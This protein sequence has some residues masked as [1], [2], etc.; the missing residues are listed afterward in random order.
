MRY[1]P[2]R[3]IA[4]L[5]FCLFAVGGAM[6]QTPEPLV[7]PRLHGPVILDGLS[8]EPAWDVAEPLPVVQ[9]EPDPGEPPTQKTEIRV[10]YDDQYLYFSLRAYDTDPHGIRANTLYR[11]RLSGDDHFEIM[12]DT[13]NDNENAILFTTTPA[14]IRRDATVSN[15][16]S[17]GGV[18]SGGWLNT[19][20]NTYWDVK[21]VVN[22]QGWFAELRIP[23][24]SL[25]FQSENGRVVMGFSVQRKV[26]R[27]SERLIYPAVPP[28]INWGFLKPS[29]G[30]K[31]VLEGIY[32]H[33]PVYVTPYILSGLSQ[34][35]RWNDAR[36]AYLSDNNVERDIGGDL[37]Y[38]LTNNLSL[39]LTINTDFAQVEADDQ[40]INLTRFSLFYPEKRQFFQ[41]RAS[42]LEFR[43]GGVSRLFHS[44]R[45]GL[46]EQG[47]QVPIIGG[48]R[49]VG[50]VGEWD[51]GAL[52]MQTAESGAL[53]SENFG[54][55][56]LRRRAFNPYSY[57]GGMST[58][59]IGTDGSYNAAYG[60]DGVFRLAGDDYLTLQWAQTFDSDL[61]EASALD[62]F[63]T[64][65]FVANLERR[66]RQG[67]GYNVGMVW[68]GRHYNPGIGFVQRT[69]YLLFDNTVSYSWLPG[70]GSDLLYHTLGVRGIVFMRNED[71][72]VESAEIGPEWE[73]GRRSGGTALV[74]AKVL[75]EDL[76]FP[77]AIARDAEVPAGTYSFYQGTVSYSMPRT[78]LLQLGIAVSAGS[79][80]DGWRLAVGL[81]P[82]WYVSPHL[83]LTGE[84]HWDR[85]RFPDRN[86]GFDA[87][88]ARLRIGTALNTNLSTNAF[89]QYN[90][91]T[92][93]VSANVRFRYN[94]REGNDLWIVYNEGLN[95]NRSRAFPTPSLPLTD[96]RTIL[97]K[98]T[99]TF[100]L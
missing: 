21:T 8:F 100:S 45:I 29:L 50:R 36:A 84:Y 12:L 53:P 67:P 2:K 15:D 95:T 27:R 91:A 79:F 49:L 22:D 33:N 74:E 18:L 4:L 88:I 72:S 9:Y 65:L 39:D 81:T 68:S 60:L 28:S 31:M 78:Q 89:I 34:A 51:L 64:A 5:C 40:Q 62:A 35:N 70:A 57:A 55:F 92:E 56:R 11:D 3:T 10:A 17:G 48:A 73:L 90:S 20:Y 38:G 83:E 44:R 41:E 76:V 16:A 86:Q 98:Y 25:R 14:G 52:N 32:P 80:Y 26:A 87:H 75:V 66:R 30:R 77:F 47:V 54:V 13:Y 93:A 6:A 23:F 37:K 19:S 43:T 96:S 46:T 61:I 99:H 82:V 85:V 1:L 69:N 58:T 94:F 7:V 24:S 63:N 59:R 71:R 97:L 42:I